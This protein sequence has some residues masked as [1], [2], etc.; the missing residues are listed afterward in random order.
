MKFYQV[1]EIAKKYIEYDMIQA[2]TKL[3]PYSH[4]RTRLLYAFLHKNRIFRKYSELYALVTSLVQL[5]LD[6]HDQVEAQLNTP[7]EKEMRSKQLK[8]LAGDYFSGRFYQLLSQAGQIEIIRNLSR[9][10]CEVNRIKM[11]LYGKMTQFKMTAE[12]YL[13]QTVEIKSKL[14]LSFKDC[15]SEFH[16]QVW[17]DI[18]YGLTECEVLLEE[19]KRVEN[20]EYFPQSWAYWYLYEQADAAEQRLL[21][22]RSKDRSSVNGMIDKYNIRHQLMSLLQKKMDD[23]L[24]RMKQFESDKLKQELV[25]IGEA[26]TDSLASVK[27]LEEI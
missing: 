15:M 27:I 23:L 4:Y 17:P 11:N 25:H 14:F 7:E 13:Q 22:D 10:I 21:V 16:Q 5:G 20:I 3:P 8:V 19:M 24:Q 6:T 18:L 12:E 1:P 2:H 9:S 26:L